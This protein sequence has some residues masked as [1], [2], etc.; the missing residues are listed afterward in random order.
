MPS[1]NY[2]L[3][4][5]MSVG[6]VLISIAFISI[7]SQTKKTENG[8]NVDIRAKAGVANSMKVTGVVASY[9]ASE[10]TL[11]VNNVN[12]QNANAN[13]PGMG[14]WTV[15]PPVKDFEPLS[16]VGKKV[17]IFVDAASFNTSAKTLTALDIKQ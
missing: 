2:T 9:N 10:N 3:F 7:L 6:F 14:T 15:V 13:S 16:S 5:V 1:K 8:E 4:F 17:T 11:T 12:F